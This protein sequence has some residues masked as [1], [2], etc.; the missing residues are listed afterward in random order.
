M[1]DSLADSTSLRALRMK[2]SQPPRGPLVAASRSVYAR[3]Q[4]P[5]EHPPLL[6]NERLPSLI[7]N[8]T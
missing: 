1:N 3:L 8:D 7:R 5:P 6:G 4:R 2:P